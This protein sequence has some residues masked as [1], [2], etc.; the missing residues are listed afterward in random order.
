MSDP[1]DLENLKRLRAK[2][3]TKEAQL[4]IAVEALDWVDAELQDNAVWSIERSRE[5]IKTAL[6]EIEKMNK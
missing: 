4:K 1:L 2:L 6:E 3:A 5:Q